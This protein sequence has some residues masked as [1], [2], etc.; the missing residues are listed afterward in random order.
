MG[1]RRWAAKTLHPFLRGLDGVVIDSDSSSSVKSLRIDVDECDIVEACARVRREGLLLAHP[2]VINSQGHHIEHPI[3]KQFN[4]LDLGAL[5]DATYLTG[6]GVLEIQ[7][8][9]IGIPV[10]LRYI[11]YKALKIRRHRVSNNN[12][13]HWVTTFEEK[14]LDNQGASAKHYTDDEVF[15]LRWLINPKAPWRGRT[16]LDTVL[17]EIRT[18][19]VA[20]AYTGSMLFHSGVPGLIIMPAEGDVQKLDEDLALKLKN[21]FDHGFN[22]TRAGKTAVLGER[23]EVQELKGAAQRLDLAGV[24]HVPEERVCSV[25]GVHPALASSVQV[26]KE[27]ESMP[28]FEQSL[29]IL[30]QLPLRLC[31]NVVEDQINMQ[32]MPLY[33]H[34]GTFRFDRRQLPGKQE[35]M[36]ALYAM[37]AATTDELRAS[38]GLDPDPSLPSMYQEKKEEDTDN[39]SDN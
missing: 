6:D 10:G 5:Y 26:L 4:T 3:V 12:S 29:S 18:D 17:T 2:F 37:Q 36:N 21:S 11:S 33:G 13:D 1:I 27:P 39:A 20:E 28:R 32:L 22:A 34:R 8:N 38:Y 19:A 15:H 31:L 25:S 24:R 9:V 35:R 30:L 14:N 16:P 23:Y 7:R